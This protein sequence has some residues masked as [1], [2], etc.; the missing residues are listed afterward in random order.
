LTLLGYKRSSPSWSRILSPL[1]HLAISAASSSTMENNLTAA[2]ASR[3]FLEE[4]LRNDWQYPDVPAIWSA[5]DEE[6]RDAVEFRER[7]YGESESG[8]SDNED[9]GDGPYKFDNP[10]SIAVAVASTRDARR[11]RRRERMEREMKE[12]EGLR[13]WVERRDTWTGATSV[14]KYGTSRQRQPDRSTSAEGYSSEEHA[15]T[16]SG[17]ESQSL[18]SAPQDTSDLVPVAPRLLDENPIRASIT[19]KTYRDIYQ[20]IV[21]SSRTPSVPI[22]LADMTKALVQGWKDSDE[23]PPR[24]G[25]VDPLAGKKRPSTGTAS[26]GHQ[27]GFIHRHPHLE[28]SVDGMKKILHL[29]A[30]HEHAHENE[31][32]PD[33]KAG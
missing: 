26:N 4:R 14:K 5:S 30:H 25:A 1:F 16:P 9:E 10:D 2:R 3:R 29:N 7:Y 12:N 8:D 28:K 13:I 24:A 6:V 33:R 15:P 22:N 11:K 27:A 31:Q 17:S 20:K 32:A 19:P 21:V 18:H 23:W